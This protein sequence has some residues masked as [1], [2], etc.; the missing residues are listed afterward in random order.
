[1]YEH[2][3][4][5]AQEYAS[6]SQQR[7]IERQGAVARTPAKKINQV[8]TKRKKQ[9]AEYSKERIAFLEYNSGCL[10]KLVGCT[11]MASEI[12]HQQGKENELLLEK[13]KWLPICRSCHNYITE[14]S[15]FAI[16]A[17]LS[18]RRNSAYVESE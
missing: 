9:L 14:N 7:A 15:G 2:Q 17:G 18:L 11:G 6:K 12:H 1:M 10:A 4:R 13:D 3:A 8:S 16:A 5:K